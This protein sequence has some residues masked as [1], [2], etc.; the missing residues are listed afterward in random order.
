MDCS[1]TGENG[2]RAEPIVERLSAPCTAETPASAIVILA[3]LWREASMRP[4]NTANRRPGA[5]DARLAV[6]RHARAR[7]RAAGSRVGGVFRISLASNARE[8]QSMLICLPL[9][10]SLSP[11][12][13]STVT[14]NC[15]CVLGDET[16]EFRGPPLKDMTGDQRQWPAIESALRSRE[17]NVR[18]GQREDVQRRAQHE[19]GCP[20]A[21]A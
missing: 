21:R 2:H 16:N 1:G 4:D 19:Q 20:N 15:F 18:S 7:N 12:P 13:G 8:A 9:I 5:P 10:F 14:V 17:R 6:R 3:P 11:A